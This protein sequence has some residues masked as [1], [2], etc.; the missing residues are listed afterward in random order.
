MT[1]YIKGTDVDSKKLL[2]INNDYYQINIDQQDTFINLERTSYPKD[3]I[4]REEKRKKEMI[5]V[6]D[7]V[8]KGNQMLISIKR[9]M[10]KNQSLGIKMHLLLISKKE[11]FLMFLYEIK[12]TVVFTLKQCSNMTIT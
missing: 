11:L 5:P 10:V 6:S 3:H 8:S 2:N 7:R 12:G 4:L 9:K 1:I